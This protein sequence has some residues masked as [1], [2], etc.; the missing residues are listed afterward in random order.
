MMVNWNSF[1]VQVVSKYSVTTL[2]LV[3][4][5][6]AANMCGVTTLY[7][8]YI[9]NILHGRCNFV[10]CLFWVCITRSSWSA[11]R[12]IMYNTHNTYCFMLDP[13][14]LQANG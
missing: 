3:Y 4:S 11:K 6:K 7:V 9:S 12:W 10:H 2:V 5:A 14:D 1:N 8:Q 13:S